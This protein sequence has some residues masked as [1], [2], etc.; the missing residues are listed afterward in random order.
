MDTRSRW[1]FRQE[2]PEA[3]DILIW[4]GPLT[5]DPFQLTENTDI[6]VSSSSVADDGLVEIKEGLQEDNTGNWIETDTQAQMAGQAQVVLSEQFLRINKGFVRIANVGAIYFYHDSTATL[7]V[8]DDL[9]KVI[10]VILPAHA[11][12][13][14]AIWTVPNGLGH[15]YVK[16]WGGGIYVNAPAEPQQR[17]AII[18][19]WQRQPGHA[20]QVIDPDVVISN[21][22]GRAINEFDGPFPTDQGFPSKTDIRV[23]VYASGTFVVAGGKFMMANEYGIIPSRRI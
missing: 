8:P 14:A 12:I 22:S 3:E 4:H 23:T 5:G 19:L 6:I 2:V 13:Q 16:R 18:S 10:A 17:D 21:G 1:G 7:G 15:F 20:W 11:H 9:T